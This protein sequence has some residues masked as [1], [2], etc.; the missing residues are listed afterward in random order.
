MC[1]NS[2]WQLLLASPFFKFQHFFL[3]N[4]FNHLTLCAVKNTASL[5]NSDDGLIGKML[6]SSS[7]W[8]LFKGC[9]DFISLIKASVKTGR[10]LL[11]LSSSL[12]MKKKNV[13]IIA[14][15]KRAWFLISG[16]CS[17]EELMLETWVSWPCYNGKL[18]LMYLIDTIIS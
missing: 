5:I 10:F 8:C 6:V 14:G 4:T 17:G 11:F 3:L 12:K 16:L 13:K 1:V 9:H 18:I 15:H 2:E 7:D